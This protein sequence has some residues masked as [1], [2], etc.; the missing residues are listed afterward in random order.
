MARGREAASCKVLSTCFEEL[1]QQAALFSPAIAKCVACVTIGWDAPGSPLTTGNRLLERVWVRVVD[2]VRSVL[3]RQQRD[4]AH[5]N[6]LRSNLAAARREHRDY[7]SGQSQREEELQRQNRAL[8]AE[9]L[10]VRADLGSAERELA[11]AGQENSRLRALVEDE[12]GGHEGLDLEGEGKSRGPEEAVNEFKEVVRQISQENMR[13][14]NLLS[15]ITQVRR[16]GG[17]TRL[18]TP[19]PSSPLPSPPPDHQRHAPR[20]HGADADGRYGARRPLA[21]AL[22]QREPSTDYIHTG[23]VKREHRTTQTDAMPSTESGPNDNDLPPPA[24]PLSRDRGGAIMPPAC[25]DVMSSLPPGGRI[26]SIRA[27][28]KRALEIF[29]AKV[30]MDKASDEGSAR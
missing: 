18:T 22:G 17:Q 16:P 2:V 4:L 6:D 3:S 14:M 24:P 19:T 5:I 1:V 12:D 20:R 25:R 30:A 23:Q 10:T 13:Q 8:R 15:T 29:L 9:L 28:K 26:M 21:L 7:V 11:I 27:V